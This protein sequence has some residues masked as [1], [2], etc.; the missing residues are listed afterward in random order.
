MVKTVLFP[1]S[2]DPF[3]AGHASIVS[4]ALKVFDAVVIGVAVNPDKE[5]HED[6][7]K[8]VKKISDRYMHDDRVVV[9]MY[10][11]LTSNIVYK[12]GINA[13][14]RGIRNGEDLNYENEITKFNYSL[15]NVET[16]YMLAEPELKEL[17]S[18]MVRE[19]EKNGKKIPEK[20][21]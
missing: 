3:T 13:V 8:S 1:G 14:I 19:L 18:T 11:G 21:K 12:F 16:L 5:R 20:F 2:F 9:I 10:T 17:S 4:R 7:A 15:F 6:V